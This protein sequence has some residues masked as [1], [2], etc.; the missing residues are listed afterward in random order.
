VQIHPDDLLAVIGFGHKGLP[1]WWRR[2]LGN[3][4]HPPEA[5]ARFFIASDRARY[6]PDLGEHLPE[7]RFWHV[8]GMPREIRILGRVAVQGDRGWPL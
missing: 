4:Q 1:D 3:F 8:F 6:S 5:E 7:T 2:T